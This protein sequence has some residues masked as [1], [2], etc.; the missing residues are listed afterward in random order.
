VYEA[1]EEHHVVDMVL[2]ALVAAN[3]KSNEFEAKAKV[4]MDLVLHHIKEEEGEMFVAAREALNEEQL[5]QKDIVQRRG[6]IEGDKHRFFLALLLNVPNRSGVLELIK[7]KFPDADPVELAVSWIKELAA[8]RI[9]GSHEPN[10][11]G[12]EGFDASHLVVFEGLLNGLEDEQIVLLTNQKT[13]LPKS[14][15]VEA[16]ALIRALPLFKSIFKK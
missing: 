15:I 13:S 11:L 6:A 1:T 14:T 5:R 3:P 4:L 2:P 16:L 7:N 10:V 9:F 12:F 8:I